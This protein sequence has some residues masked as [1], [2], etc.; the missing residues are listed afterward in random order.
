MPSKTPETLSARRQE[1]NLTNRFI[2]LILCMTAFAIG[3]GCLLYRSM[4][5][6]SPERL[7][8]DLR[9]IESMIR[10]NETT[11][12]R[13]IPHESRL[14]AAAGDALTYRVP[15]LIQGRA[16]H[17]T[18]TGKELEEVAK[19]LALEDLLAGHR[20]TKGRFQSGDADEWKTVLLNASAESKEHLKKAELPQIERRIRD[21]L[22]E[23]TNLES[24]REGLLEKAEML[25][26]R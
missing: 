21:L 19:S 11:V 25:T 7:G 4:Q 17:V 15:V 6:P 3:G 1:S 9:R 18:M 10:E 22:E 8:W 12:G 14:A 26:R 20:E 16:V 5:N 24:R 23:R 2:F 13:L